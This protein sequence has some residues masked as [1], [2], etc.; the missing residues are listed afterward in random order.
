MDLRR[1]EIERGT[2]LIGLNPREASR[3]ILRDILRDAGFPARSIDARSI[4]R[5]ESRNLEETGPDDGEGT[6]SVAPGLLGL[7]T[8]LLGVVGYVGYALYPRFDLPAAE[9][10]A[11]T[12]LALG[13]GVA[14]FFSPCAFGL[15]ATL[16]TTESRSD[17]NR[18]GFREALR[19]ASGMSLGASVFVLG[20]GLAISV[21]GAG[22]VS[23]VTFTSAA[24]QALRIAVGALLLILGFVQLGLIPSPLHRVEDWMRPLQRWSA[25]ERRHRPLLGYAIFG[26]GYLLAGFG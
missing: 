20:V 17:S 1:A 6:E 22:L 16:L 7:A 9:G 13:A 18:S 11:L 25:R 14:S 26:F 3:D 23:S 10:M 15:L 5:S 8:V 21:G 24:G 19:F 2:L 4:D 12:A